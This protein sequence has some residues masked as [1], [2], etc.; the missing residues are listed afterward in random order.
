MENC[1][2]SS[3]PTVVGTVMKCCRLKD[4]QK[5]CSLLE[6]LQGYTEKDGSSE[7]ICRAYLRCIEH[8]YFKVRW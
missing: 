7:E 5:V 3:V 8:L 4:E 6:T 1:Q 2:F